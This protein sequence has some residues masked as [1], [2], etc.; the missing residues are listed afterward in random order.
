MVGS[1]WISVSPGGKVFG[2]DPGPDEHAVVCWDPHSPKVIE[3]HD[4]STSELQAYLISQARPG[5][6]VV[7]CEWVAC[8]GMAVG[9]PIFK[10]VF[11]TGRIACVAPDCRFVPRVQIKMHL[12]GTA[13]AKDPNVSQA[14]K[15][16]FGECGTKNKPGA[17]YG[18]TKHRWAALAVAVYAAE[19]IQPDKEFFPE[20]GLLLAPIGEQV[21]RASIGDFSA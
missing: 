18:I 1:D 5:I 13:R 17:L 6:D 11:Q 4:L 9:F 15:D 12:C 2:I 10:T 8:F 21:L 14:L 7:A 3:A 20:P 16:R 19:Q